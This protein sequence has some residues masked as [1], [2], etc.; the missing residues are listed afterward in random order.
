MRFRRL[1]CVNTEYVVLIIIATF[2]ALG[3][4]YL[5]PEFSQIPVWRR[6]TEK[7]IGDLLQNYVKSSALH[8]NPLMAVQIMHDRNPEKVLMYVAI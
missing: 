2:L 4:L 7:Q 5:T 8:E 1:L 6:P 3:D